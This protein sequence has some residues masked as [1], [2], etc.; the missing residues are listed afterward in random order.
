MKHKKMARLAV[1]AV[2]SLG[3]LSSAMVGASGA[4]VASA[5]PEDVD[6]VA[7]AY[8]DIFGVSQAEADARVKRQRKL[9]KL[10]DK[11]AS[12]EGE[13]FAGAGYENG[14]DF[15]A[16]VV[17]RGDD[18][19]SRKTRRLTDKNPDLR[20]TTGALHNLDDLVAAAESSELNAMLPNFVQGIG[21]N[22]AS[23]S[24]TLTLDSDNSPVRDVAPMPLAPI[25]SDMSEDVVSARIADATALEVGIPASFNGISILVADVAAPARPSA[26]IRG[27]GYLF[28]QTSPTEVVQCSTAFSVQVDGA[29]AVLTAGH[30]IE[31]SQNPVLE[32]F[33]TPT[34]PSGN[35]AAVG[36]AIWGKKGDAGLMFLSLDDSARAKFW[37][38]IR[39][40]AVKRS[41]FA[42]TGAVVCQFGWGSATFGA[43]SR[44]C[45]VVEDANYRPLNNYCDGQQC[46]AV[47]QKISDNDVVV[48]DGDSGGPAWTRGS[49][50]AG[51]I[52]GSNHQYDPDGNPNTNNDRCEPRSD[53]FFIIYP[54]RKAINAL[55]AKTGQTIELVCVTPPQGDECHNF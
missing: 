36:P 50:P 27:G 21:V 6:F 49:T 55:A 40:R 41:N 15:Y 5:E 43:A 19:V 28:G 13:R 11:I 24:L 26:K 3:L 18:E 39:Y 37:D 31:D 44:T 7:E 46:N 45:G 8:A 4:S 16:Y 25:S 52:S 47:F 23:N 33:T 22:V 10:I 35:E 1:V 53:G 51:I 54:V 12:I 48:C 38:G 30:C 17:L 9:D 2:L 29:D 34:S 20:I 32:L 14:E 42:N